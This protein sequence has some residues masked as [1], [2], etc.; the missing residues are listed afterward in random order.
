MVVGAS[1]GGVRSMTATSGG[2]F[3]LMTEALGM[4]GIMELPVVFVNGMRSGPSTGMPTWHDQGDLL[5]CV[6]AGHGEFPKMVVTP[7]DIKENFDW[8]RKAFYY[9]EKYQLPVV[10][11]TDKYLGESTQTIENIKPEYKNNRY[12]FVKNSQKN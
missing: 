5:F 10:I 8:T 7:G 11:V 12:G 9:S 1:F 3:C 6:N 4:A 2:G